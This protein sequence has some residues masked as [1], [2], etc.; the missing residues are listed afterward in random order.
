[1][2]TGIDTYIIKVA[3]FCNLNC[4]YCY[5]F[6]GADRSFRGRPKIISPEI[7][8]EMT[9]KIIVHAHEHGLRRVDL[10]LH[11]GEPLLI[12]RDRFVHMMR[13]FDR[14][15]EAGIETRRKCQTNAVMLDGEWANLFTA[16][17]ILLG[18]SIDGPREAHD[19]F[20]V[21]HAGNGSYDRTVRG[22]RQA[23]ERE[24]DGLR[25]SV[26]CFINPKYSGA[27][28][29]RHLREL[30]ATRMD[31]L[32]P[33]SNYA[34]PP[35]GYQPLG[36]ATPYGDYLIEVFD[37]W[38]A[39][40]DPTVHVRLLDRIV[41]SVLG[42]PVNS[43]VISA[44]PVRVAVIE[45]DGSIEPTDNFKACADRMTDLG[46]NIATNDFDDLYH[47]PFFKH[48]LEGLQ[49]IPAECTG[50]RYRQV[51][52]GGR[53]TTRYSLDAQFANRTIYCNDLYRLYDHV[54]ARVRSMLG[55]RA[56]AVGGERSWRP[57]PATESLKPPAG[58]FR[59][60]R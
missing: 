18:I 12:S 45:T 4:S 31:F 2:A 11:G 20:R 47:H 8:R 46:L 26:L 53:I 42:Q 51:C 5:Y 3:S 54:R 14:I 37:A 32:L 30:G 28:M 38:I 7:L 36:P 48:C 56:V 41:R 10:T 43:D 16:W 52:G 40:N 60:R 49:S 23:L 15:D 57:P 33:E 29:Y 19:E 34:Y 35:P 21:D 39:E 50:C 25:T 22:L 6:N 58:E 13:E 17:N 59:D 27:A 44:A 24:P 9:D 55:D 1:M